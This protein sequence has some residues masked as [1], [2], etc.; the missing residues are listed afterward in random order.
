[1]LSLD[2][3]KSRMR[4]K[5]ALTSEERAFFTD[6]S[7]TKVNCSKPADRAFVLN[8]IREQWGTEESFNHYVQK[9]LPGI[10]E[11]SKRKYF[12]QASAVMA[13]VLDLSFGGA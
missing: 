9:A 11:R 10:M 12:D 2:W 5:I 8:A 4:S 13:R 1:V 3:P 7:C 6:F